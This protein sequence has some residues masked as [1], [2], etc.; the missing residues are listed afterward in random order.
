[1]I[2][3]GNVYFWS[4]GVQLLKNYL[5]KRLSSTLNCLCIFVENWLIVYVWV[6]CQILLTFWSIS[7][8]LDSYSFIVS[9][10]IRYSEYSSKILQNYFRHCSY[11]AFLRTFDNHI[12]WV[13][14]FI[15]IGWRQSG[16]SI[17]WDNLL[18]KTTHKGASSFRRMWHE[19]VYFF[20]FRLLK[21]K[22]IY[23]NWRLITLQYCSGFAIHCHESAMGVHVSP[24]L[25]PNP[26]SIPIP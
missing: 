15:E 22:F 23:F 8:C 12:Y 20:F 2:V 25:N 19:S 4:Y 21:N 16:L 7:H 1:M 18:W 11:I 3:I 26:T 17:S 10:H 9:L 13:I 6:Y 24:I 5:L 14:I